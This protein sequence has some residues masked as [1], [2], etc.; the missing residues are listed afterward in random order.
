[1]IT[2][3][4]EVR[5]AKLPEGKVTR[6]CF[7]IVKTSLSPLKDEDAL[8]KNVWM[9]VDPYMRLLMQEGSEDSSDTLQP[10]DVFIGGAIGEVVESKYK[11]L[12]TGDFVLSD[13]GWREHFI[14]SGDVLAKVDPGLVPLQTYLGVAGLT[15]MTAWTGLFKLAQPKPG[16]TVFVTAASGAVGSIV[17]QLA[18]SAGCYVAGSAGTDDKVS[19]LTNTL[20]IDAAF[21][22]RDVPDIATAM[23]E[24]C[25][26]GIDIYFENVGGEQLEAALETMNDFGRITLCGMVAMYDGNYTSTPRNILNVIYKCL[27]VEGYDVTNERYWKDYPRFLEEIAPLMTDNKLFWKETVYEGIEKAPDAL[28]ALLTGDN[29]GKMLVKLADVG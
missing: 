9:S 10:G 29:F 28:I 18:K 24:V 27:K 23:S 6:D 19:W 7:E 4:N 17:C 16:E 13:C 5:L 3:T 22:Y 11:G 20:G 14:C 26:N 15:G 1:M 8:V 2:D 21:N 25:P 12:K